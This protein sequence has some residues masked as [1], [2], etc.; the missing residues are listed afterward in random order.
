MF[1]QAGQSRALLRAIEAISRNVCHAA[2]PPGLAPAGQAIQ[3]PLKSNMR[4]MGTPRRRRG[5]PVI[6]R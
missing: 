3:H 4:G 6:S 5:A 1:L 2:A